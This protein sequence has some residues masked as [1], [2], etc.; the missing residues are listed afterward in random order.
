[1][2]RAFQ[3]GRVGLRG[4]A[5][6]SAA[7]Q[8]GEVVHLRQTRLPKWQV[9]SPRVV[10]LRPGAITNSHKGNLAHDDIIGR[11][12]YDE[13]RTHTGVSYTVV[14]PAMDEYIRHTRRIS[15]PIYQASVIVCW[16]RVCWRAD[17]N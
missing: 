12:A 5:Y 10:K 14:R 3:R 13:V 9:E 15:T 6:K 1:M 4:I 7:L 11:Q 17:A 2:R 16:Y 8:A